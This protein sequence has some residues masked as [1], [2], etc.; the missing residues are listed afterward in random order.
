MTP[1]ILFTAGETQFAQYREPL[2][3][4]LA[5]VGVSADLG[6][7]HA[8]NEVDYLVHSA[9]SG[10][11]T[12]FTPFTRAKAVLNLWAGVETLVTNPTLTQPLARM[13]DNG[14]TE[15][16]SEWV[17]GHV[18]RHHLDLDTFTLNQT[19][20]SHPPVPPLARDRRVGFL[21]L[22]RLGRAAA[23]ML[24]A[25]NFD[26]AGWSG[27]PKN[28]PGIDTFHGPEGLAPLLAR[29]EILVLLLPLT[30]G[31]RN[32]LNAERLAQLPHGAVVL[33]PGRGP[34]ID[35]TA[36]LAALDSGQVG[37][38]TLDVFRQEPLPA[39]H[40]FWAHPRVTVTPHVASTT[41]P[42]SASRVI[43]ENVRRGEAGEPFLH[44]VDRA[45][46]Y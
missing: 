15:G 46:G 7:D 2:T 36:L 41:R 20:W 30:D 6:R 43:A 35:D 14:M 16:M 33:N 24:A 39:D 25:L 10:E 13:V 18:L 21:G 40:P 1:K 29:S 26:V 19:G 5:E 9:H 3:A 27:S 37:A 28:I 22:G 17:A 11:V 45:A 12:D 38:A 4:A 31:T 23:E 34:L 42:Q 44:L 8:P 32:I